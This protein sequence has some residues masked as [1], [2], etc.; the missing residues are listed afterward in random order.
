MLTVRHCIVDTPY[1]ECVIQYQCIHSVRRGQ[2]DGVFSDI[3]NLTD[4]DEFSDSRVIPQQVK[5]RSGVYVA[6][7]E[8]G[9]GGN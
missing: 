2:T 3:M 5:T 1:K 6:H 7:G 4:C 8:I 9:I